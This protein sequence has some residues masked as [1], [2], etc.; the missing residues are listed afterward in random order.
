MRIL[1]TSDWHLGKQLHNNAMLP[2]QENALHFLVNVIKEQK[3]DALLVSGDIFH[4]TNPSND[5]MKLFNDF[6]I[7]IYKTTDCNNIIITAGNH[8]SAQRIEITK[9]T[10]KILNIHLI[11]DSNDI[12][13]Q[14]IEVKDKQDKIIGVVAAVPYL[15]IR[16]MNAV[17]IDG[18]F[19]DHKITHIKKSILHHLDVIANK[20]DEL[21][22]NISNKVLMAHLFA[23]GSQTRENQNNIYLHDLENI[24]ADQFPKTFKYVALGHIHIPQIIGQQEHIRY[25][26]SLIQLH[27]SARKEKKIIL[28][29]DM[30]D[31]KIDDIAPIDMPVFREM[32][33][34]KGTLNELTTF[35]ST[36]KDDNELTTWLTIELTEFHNF[37][38][39][40]SHIKRLIDH[41]NIQVSKL[42]YSSEI[43]SI[44]KEFEMDD[45]SI[46]LVNK[47]IHEIF[48]EICKNKGHS[49]EDTKRLKSTFDEL[50][51]LVD[52]EGKLIKDIPEA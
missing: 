51:T 27:I 10:Y 23:K 2:E 52:E 36:L 9:K 37:D 21:Y 30:N 11:G 18:E 14:I 1:H 38:F 43:K 16:N 26:G 3:P 35:I 5:A 39:I 31:G 42:G 15:H 46:L 29:V 45:D 19:R 17:P 13:E 8:D 6:L 12:D 28:I 44:R 22:P 48:G 7:K 25:S 20:C 32:H 34:F 33:A 24:T 41:K 49:V 47:D 4:T 50:L 40:Q